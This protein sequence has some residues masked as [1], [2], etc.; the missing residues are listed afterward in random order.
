MGLSRPGLSI[1]QHCHVIPAEQLL[2]DVFH[3]ST[4]QLLVAA[5]FPEGEVVGETLLRIQNVNLMVTYLK[6]VNLFNL[7]HLR[8]I[9]NHVE[10]SLATFIIFFPID[11]PDS[12]SHPHW[13][14][15]VVPHGPVEP[16]WPKSKNTTTLH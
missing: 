15:F 7:P 12:D 8:L 13:D 11:W 6:Y 1:C 4:V 5:I 9:L 16:K 2:Y 14:N 10:S 3:S